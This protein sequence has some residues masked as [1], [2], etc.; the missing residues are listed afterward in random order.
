[1]DRLTTE[2]EEREF[3]AFI[4]ALFSQDDTKK[5]KNELNSLEVP[6]PYRL[7][8]KVLYSEK[9]IKDVFEGLT[10]K[11]FIQ[12]LRKESDTYVFNSIVGRKFTTKINV[13]FFL[14]TF[15]DT[16]LNENVQAII[17][18][19]KSDSW[20]ALRSF[21]KKSY[22]RLVPILLSQSELI[23]STKGLKKITGHDIRANA[24]SA[25]ESFDGESKT[26]K[27]SVRTWTDEDVDETILTAEERGQVI[28]SIDVKFFRIIDDT[29]NVMPDVT[30]KIRK[31]GEI[32]VTGK[33]SLA[34]NAV[35]KQIAE[36]GYN[37]LRFLSK[38]GLRISLYKPRPLSMNF[39]QPVFEKVESIR[40]FV[41]ILS[42]YPRSM[43]AIEH[44]NPYAHVKLS[45]T[46]DGSSFDIWAISPSRIALMPG[47]KASEA[48][49]ERLIHYIY[50]NFREGQLT[51]YG[52]RG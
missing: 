29:P 27:K 14:N 40:Q 45:D 34:F 26:F 36:I 35:A 12:H 32:E 46:Y 5:I 44:G 50:D 42:K 51:D 38:R 17:A 18:I 21:T 30:C 49:F 1:M 25:K 16:G 6:Y 43:H 11:G 52:S 7:R 15:D 31:N 22:P 41:Q 3:E 24:Y 19:C 28:T 4:K 2:Q 9:G 47:L 33:Y 39:T 8:I 48:A 10:E 13:P 23:K 37:K 20:Q